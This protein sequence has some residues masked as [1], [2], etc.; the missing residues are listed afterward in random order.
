MDNLVYPRER[1]L[2]TITL[3]IG[4]IGWFLV[5]VGTVGIALLYILIGF[6][7]YLFAQ[8]A[9]IAYIKGTGAKLS[10]QQY[11]DL[12]QRFVHCCDKLGVSDRPDVYLLHGDG[13]FN[14]F[15]TKFL[16]RNFVILLS[17]VVDA[18]DD[19]PDG[20]NFYMG[21]ELGHIR[22][23]H[24]SGNVL[25]WPALWIP[26]LGAGYS[27]AKEST[28]DRHGNACCESP[29]NAA[30]A[31]AA[32]AAGA[33]RWKTM[34][35][36]A[37]TAQAKETSG[38]WMSYH[39]LTGSYPWLTKRIARI[40]GEES[41]LPS[42]HGL[43]WVLAALTPNAGRASGS[44]GPFVMIAIIGILAAI[45]LPAYQD[46][47]HRAKLSSY[48][49][50]SLPIAETVGTYFASKQ[51]MP[52]DLESIGLPSKLPGGAEVSI[53]REGM[54]LNVSSPDGSFVL[55]GEVGAD[56][57]IR[58]TCDSDGSTRSAWLPMACRTDSPFR[59]K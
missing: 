5:I 12:Y 30:R 19:L 52:S 51:E 50:Q 2:G 23:K 18:M 40:T 41:S 13:M 7:A 17:D 55:Q 38:F 46:Y 31:M 27:R 3:I 42:R 1:S 25:R 8:S 32:L 4:L 34:D 49:Q 6:L 9:F 16:G 22:M 56:K 36:S 15:A 43:A 47:T 57:K 45:A 39:E 24:L 26:L 37:Y 44:M 10:P 14:A 48:Y 35:I 53:D 21:H 29:E 20:V 54:A 33:K 59:M 28:C 58:W 11:P